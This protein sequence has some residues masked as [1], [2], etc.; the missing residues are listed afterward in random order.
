[1]VI[2]LDAA[3]GLLGLVAALLLW[4]VSLAGSDD[5]GSEPDD[6]GPDW[7]RGRGPD[8]PPPESPSW[9]PEFERQFAEHAS[10]QDA[11]HPA[12]AVPAA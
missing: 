4:H 3:L 11:R 7:R 1:M 8:G 2:L 10:R 9:W 12:Q 5:G 6:D